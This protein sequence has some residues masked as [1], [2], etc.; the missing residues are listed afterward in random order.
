MSADSGKS[1]ATSD[2]PNDPTPAADEPS[3]PAGL[4]PALIATL[5]A[6]PIM[7]LV[8]FITFAALKPDDAS[9][10]D[11]YV[12]ASNT[13]ADCAKLVTALPIRFDG[14]GDK[15][16]DGSVVRWAS[17]SDGE[18]ISLR[19]GVGRPDGLAPSSK[20]QVVHPVQWFITDTIDGR[21]QA[22]VAV[23]HRPYVALWIPLNAGNAA[24]T[25]VSGVIDRTLPRAPL[26]L[27]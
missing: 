10:I 23:D 22:Y 7:V 3:E 6:I 26:D 19:C 2:E 16:V 17:T 13:G 20:L 4:H 25:E 5:V 12:A 14:Y 27:G 9:P 21:G 8:G 1:S 11:T 24:I 15:S 18:A